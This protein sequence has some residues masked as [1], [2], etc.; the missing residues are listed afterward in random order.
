ME[1]FR[2][3][4][5]FG[6]G[7][8]SKEPRNLKIMVNVRTSRSLSCTL[9]YQSILKNLSSARE[10][11]FVFIHFWDFWGRGNDFK[12]LFQH[13]FLRLY[14]RYHSYRQHSKS[15]KLHRKWKKFLI[16]RTKNYQNPLSIRR[17]TLDWKFD[18]M[19][20]VYKGD[21]KKKCF[22]NFEILSRFE[23]IGW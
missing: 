3:S 19:F 18:K 14:H 21:W 5:F 17:A 8:P 11:S 22:G 13:W 6:H 20:T 23:K 4:E 9:C 1:E 7:L 15:T 10:F 12:R 16:Q 2:K